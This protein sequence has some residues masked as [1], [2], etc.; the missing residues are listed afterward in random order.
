M[1]TDSFN[2]P[3]CQSSWKCKDRPSSNVHG[4]LP[5]RV[6]TVSYGKWQLSG[7]TFRNFHHFLTR[8]GHVRLS[9]LICR[10]KHDRVLPFDFAPTHS[11]PVV[12]YGF[13]IIDRSCMGPLAARCRRIECGT[14]AHVLPWWIRLGRRLF[15][16]AE[17]RGVDLRRRHVLREQ[18]V[19][20]QGLGFGSLHCPL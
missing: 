12:I 14:N 7:L 5:Q 4:T 9:I 19:A 11:S 2:H 20:L 17:E 6:F 10:T 18:G 13:S 3:F 16:P 8:S 1:I 15:V